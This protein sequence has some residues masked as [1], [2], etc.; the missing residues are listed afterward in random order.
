M[1]FRAAVLLV[2]L[3]AAAAA[4]ARDDFLRNSSRDLNGREKAALEERLGELGSSDAR[5]RQQAVRR[6]V[7]IGRASVPALLDVVRN[8]SE[9]KRVRNSCLA[10]GAQADPSGLARLEKWL[11]ERSRPEEATRAALFALMRDRS[12]LAPELSAHL[13]RLALEASI[14]TVRETALLC[15]G[16]RRVGGLSLLLQAPLQS[17]RSARVRGCMLVALAE[18]GDAAGAPLVARFL[19][20][21]HVRDPKLR[22]AALYAASRLPDPLLLPLL[23]RFE[24]DR[25]EVAAYAIAL[26]AHAAPAAVDRLGELLRRH[27][28]LAAPAACS[29][30]QIVSPEAKEWLE[31]ALAGEFSAAVQARAACAVADLIDQQRFLPHLRTLALGP[32]SAPGKAAALLAL[33]RIGD[34]ESASAIADALPLWRDP[35]LIERGLLLCART[36]DRRVEELVP[37]ARRGAVGPLWRETVEIQDEKRDIRLLRERVADALTAARGHWLLARDDLRLAVVRDLLELDVDLP[38]E[39]RNDGGGS[40]GETPP[41]G[42]GDD[43]GGGGGGEGDGEGGDGTTPPPP[44]GAD[45]PPTLPGIGLRRGRYDPNKFE[46][47]LRAFLLDHA[48]FGAADPYAP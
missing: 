22:R 24:P 20:P 40:S 45:P 17:E 19:D 23:L 33:A 34:R 18:A 35:L 48:P 6:F 41:P 15:A 28:D 16:V 8:D 38:P 10:L 31:R 36:L 39:P 11:I 13:R 21:R 2:L 47:D 30:A 26:G 25:D 37:E 44:P 12:P 3:V 5:V 46:H 1:P 43:G 4:P 42:G 27:R 29:L 32:P 7:A 14:S 9:P